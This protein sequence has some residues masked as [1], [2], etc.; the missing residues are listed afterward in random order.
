MALPVALQFKILMNDYVKAGNNGNPDPRIR[1]KF[2]ET[3]IKTW[4]FVLH[5]IDD[6]NECGYFGGVYLG[7]FCMKDTFPRDAPTLE[8]I[9][10]NGRCESKTKLCVQGITH[11]HNAD[12]TAAQ[13]LSTDL[14]GFLSYFIDDS[15]T[16]KGI[17]FITMDEPKKM[18][19]IGLKKYRMK[20]ALESRSYNS[21]CKEF[22]DLF[23]EFLEEKWYIL[24]LDKIL[25]PVPT[26]SIAPT[27]A[28]VHDPSPDD[29]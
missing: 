1:I 20:L 26:S 9:T 7:K 16:S 4:Y 2:Y 6:K 19:K 10:P 28:S 5:N 13:K 11:Y 24:T 25:P 17:G 29:E 23:P 14:V 18:T 15:S 27:P 21:K 3:D 22:T 12:R 8:M